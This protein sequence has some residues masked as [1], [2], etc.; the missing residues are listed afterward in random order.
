MFMYIN[1]SILINNLLYYIIL[2]F[3]IV[4]Y[5]YYHSLCLHLGGRSGWLCSG[6]TLAD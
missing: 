3:T 2:N 4:W 1:L 5:N 6:M